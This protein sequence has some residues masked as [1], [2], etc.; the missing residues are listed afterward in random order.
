MITTDITQQ[1][2]GTTYVPFSDGII[3]QTQGYYINPDSTIY[4]NEGQIFKTSSFNGDVN[5]K[6]KCEYCG[7][8]DYH[9][10]CH[11]HKTWCPYYCGGHSNTLSL[12][13]DVFILSVMIILY[14]LYKKV[15]NK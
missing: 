9:A 5:K 1:N 2:D 4:K 6:H 14:T 7:K 12:N 3:Y 15:F 8:P 13:G 10:D 11:A